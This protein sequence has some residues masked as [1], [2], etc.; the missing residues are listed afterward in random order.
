M[1]IATLKRKTHAQY[2]NISVNSKHGFSLNGT[3]RSQGYIGQTSLS[4]S[5]PRT[6]IRGGVPR[7]HGGCCGTFIK[8]P[9]I[10]SAVT[11]LNNLN[12]IKPSSINTLGM[13]ENK[14]KKS[15][16]H[17]PS[18]KPDNNQNINTQNQYIKNLAKDT[19]DCANSLKASNDEIIAASCNAC[20]NYNSFYKKKLINFT[21][22]STLPVSQGE[23]LLKLIEKCSKLDTVSVPSANNKGV[24]PGPSASY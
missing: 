13:I 6:L 19:I 3:T 15:L 5:L 4:R 1:S 17:E 21:K 16:N 18:V 11:S 12:I 10:T 9:I 23:H 22:V 8:H 7:G 14:Y 24:L 2:N 20:Y